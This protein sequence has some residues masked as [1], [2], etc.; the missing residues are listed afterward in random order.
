M[1]F[2]K[3]LLVI[4]I[5]IGVITLLLCIK[6]PTE[7]D[8][9]GEVRYKGLYGKLVNIEG[10]GVSGAKVKAI[11]VRKVGL[12]KVQEGIISLKDSP[13]DSVYTDSSGYYSFENLEAGIY[14]LQIVMGGW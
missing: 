1:K 6:K 2:F 5:L 14:N 10:K 4:T 8:I 3:I 7:P 11:N 12:Q 13:F 9:S